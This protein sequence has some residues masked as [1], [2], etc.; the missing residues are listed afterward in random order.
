TFTMKLALEIC[1]PKNRK[2][3]GA[4]GLSPLGAR[5]LLNQM[6]LP[7]WIAVALKLERIEAGW[8]TSTLKEQLAVFWDESLAVQITT[9]EPTGRLE[10]EGGWQITLDSEQ[11]SVA[12]TSNLTIA[13]HWPGSARTDRS[14]GHKRWGGALSKTVTEAVHEAETPWVLITLSVT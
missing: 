3:T 10:P 6:V 13:E 14:A 4:V 1:C 12:L 8:T 7:A 9:L 11:V 2:V 5:T